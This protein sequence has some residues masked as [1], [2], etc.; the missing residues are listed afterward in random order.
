MIVNSKIALA[1]AAGAM[2]AS[3]IVYVA[4]KPPVAPPR[5]A[6]VVPPPPAPKPA[7]PA[8]EPVSAPA[9]TPTIE[10]EPP[11][12]VSPRLIPKSTDDTRHPSKA[13]RYSA[14]PPRLRKMCRLQ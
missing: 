7:A 11:K 13:P 1:F 3:G 2:L 8:V 6:A 5:V 12:P 9:H 10:P 14:A 4:L